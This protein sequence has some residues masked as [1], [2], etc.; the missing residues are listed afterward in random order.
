MGEQLDRPFAHR[1]RFGPARAAIR[2]GRGRV[3][4]DRHAEE[5]DLGNAV[6]ARRHEA[7][8]PRDEHAADRI[9]ADVGERA[10]A[11]ADD[12]RRSRVA[13][14]SMSCTWSR[15]CV[16]LSRFSRAGLGP[17]DRPPEALRRRRDHDLLVVDAAL[18][19]EATADR[20]RAHDHVCALV[21]PERRR[22]LVAYAEDR[23]RARPH[24]EPIAVGDAT[25]P[26]GSI[27]T[28][29]MRRWHDARPHHDLGVGPAVTRGRHGARRQVRPE[30]GKQQWRLRRS[31]RRVDDGWEALGVDDD[32]F[33][34]VDACARVSATTTATGSP[35]NRTRSV[36]SRGRSSLPSPPIARAGGKSRSASVHTAT[37][38][39]VPAR[40]RC[41]NA[42]ELA[43]GV[44]RPHEDGPQ[45]ARCDRSRRR[46][47]SAWT[48]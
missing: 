21:E 20:G 38:P 34:R 27:G 29:A 44:H 40:P 32:E 10:H 48:R 25:A 39:G 4:D 42:A 8:H 31:R 12:R 35:T 6:D 36:A 11:Q 47:R 1:R 43:V 24:R 46:R 33:G 18:G 9:R 7:R 41:R 14:I 26:F 30:L 22:D 3:R 23:L 2:T 15:P 28:G 16:M 45:R 19:A 13:P 37:T 5:L 17:R